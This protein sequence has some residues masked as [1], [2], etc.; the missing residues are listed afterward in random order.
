MGTQPAIVVVTLTRVERNCYDAPVAIA[1]T[2]TGGGDDPFQ[3]AFAGM[4][5]LMV[6]LCVHLAVRPYEAN[7]LNVLETMSLATT[8]ATQAALV[9]YW[10]QEDIGSGIAVFT[11]CLNVALICAFGFVALPRVCSSKAS[12]T[13]RVIRKTLV[14]AGRVPGPSR[15]ALPTD[16]DGVEMTVNPMRPR[17]VS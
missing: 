16:V 6:A 10:H 15:A 4:C 9:Q 8:V 12:C 3:Q 14:L 5:V 1:A 7:V 13:G 11:I 17:S 2:A